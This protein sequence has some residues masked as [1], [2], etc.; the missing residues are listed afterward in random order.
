MGASGPT[1]KPKAV[2]AR[3][4]SKNGRRCVRASGN[5]R[6]PRAAAMY[7][8]TPKAGARRA[9]AP[10]TA[11]PAAVAQGIAHGAG[12]RCQSLSAKRSAAA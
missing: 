10:T 12:A 2:V 4:V 8:A 11:P 5:G 7:P 6:A 3:L 1:E 9:S